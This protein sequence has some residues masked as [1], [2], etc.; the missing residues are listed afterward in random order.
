MSGERTS[1]FP[2]P[3]TGRTFI[4]V[5]WVY[6]PTIDVGATHPWKY[7]PLAP[8]PHSSESRSRASTNSSEEARSSPRRWYERGAG[9]GPR[10]TFA[11]PRKQHGARRRSSTTRTRRAAMQAEPQGRASLGAACPARPIAH[12]AVAAALRTRAAAE[13]TSDQPSSTKPQRVPCLPWYED[14]LP[15]GTIGTED[16]PPAPMLE[17]TEG[18]PR[19]LNSFRSE[20]AGPGVR[21]HDRHEPD[22]RPRP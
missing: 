22:V 12:Q 20:T 10:L 11:V 19:A 15:W 1:L 3:D 2:P 18:A 14:W 4:S 7:S 16:R 6:A 5:S 17:A 13:Q 21:A 9:F 8:L